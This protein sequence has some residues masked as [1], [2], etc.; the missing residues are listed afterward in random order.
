RGP[1]SVVSS[2]RRH[3]LV[4]VL[5][6]A[7]LTAG[8]SAAASVLSSPA[9][10]A[11]AFAAPAFAAPA[12]PTGSLDDAKAKARTLRLQADKLQAQAEQA[13]E[14]YD[15]AY[16]ELGRVVTAHL[17]AERALDNAVSQADDTSSTADRRVRALY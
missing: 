15:A 1:A 6:A 2:L 16:D 10:A 4:P 13:T 3:R 5:L 8:V 7:A 9:L 17:T 12:R 11:P 14:A